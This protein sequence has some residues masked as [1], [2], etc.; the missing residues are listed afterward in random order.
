[1]E[2]GQATVPQMPERPPA[3]VLVA[4]GLIAGTT[5][6]LQVLLTR[7]FSAALFYHFGFLAISLA[8]LGTGAGAIL[9]YLRPGWFGRPF[10]PQ[11]AR[12]TAVLAL[13]LVVVP[14]I[15]VRLD[16]TFPNEITAR[17]ALT[18]AAACVLAAGPF[19]V[20]GV[21]IALAITRYTRWIGRVYAFDLAG[22]G[23]GALAIVPV[24]WLVAAPPLIAVLGAIVAGAAI[25]LAGA[26]PGLRGGLAVA[27]LALAC[28]ALSGPLELYR[29]PPIDRK[30]VV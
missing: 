22:A 21:V 27:A 23:L 25:L 24:L 17:F 15:L 9:V 10:R 2:V 6:A 3:G 18:L 5:L 7:V 19:F 16:Y 26:G 12:W 4:V 29:L 13:L 20:A 14:A 1:M 8:L 11:L 28:V 30:S